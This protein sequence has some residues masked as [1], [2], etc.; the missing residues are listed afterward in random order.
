MKKSLNVFLSGTVKD[1]AP[2]REIATR[3][4]ES[5]KLEAVRMETFGASSQTPLESCRQMVQDSDVFIGIY[6]GRYG[7]V[8]PNQSQSASEI[9][10]QEAQRLGKDIMI[11]IKESDEIQ[12]EQLRF[13]QRVDDFE[14]GYFRRPKFRTLSE[15]EEWIKEDLIA[16]LSSRFVTTNVP[17]AG[18]LTD[19]YRTY[20]SN[21]YGKV[22]FA[23]LAQT[24]SGLL[25]PLQDIYIA[26][27]LREV[28][29]SK[30]TE[31][32][33]FNLGEALPTRAVI[34]GPPGS[35]KTM[36]LKHLACAAAEQ[37]APQ[38]LDRLPLLVPLISLA[39]ENSS[40][41]FFD[42]LGRFVASRTEGRF[43]SVIRDALAS[44]KT[45][46]LLDGLDEIAEPDDVDRVLFDLLTFCEQYP[47]TPVLLTT[48]PSGWR[49]IRGFLNCEIQ[50]FTDEQIFRFVRQWSAALG[51]DL[52]VS[53]KSDELLHTLVQHRYLLE[54]AR[55]PLFLTLLAFVH[56]Q[57]YRLPTRR[58]E[59]YDAYTRTMIDSWD[60][61]RSL[62]HTLARQFRQAEVED[63]LSQ[64]AFTMTTRG[65]RTIEA[66]EILSLVPD[67]ASNAEPFRAPEML[68]ALSA[69]TG[70]LDEI[71]QGR[72]SFNHI[73]F[74][75]FFAAKAIASRKFF[76]RSRFQVGY[77][78]GR[79]KST[80]VITP[81]ARAG[82]WVVDNSG[83][84]R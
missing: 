33:V 56:R 41:N 6:G 2:E 67:Y 39:E 53:A 57:G 50:P 12:N 30:E 14:G 69:R 71:A 21:L 82:P 63:F 46:L 9:E 26:P 76:E 4:I 5:L 74:Q 32:R 45:I 60:R 15:L 10:F 81:V 25:V 55:N 37:S 29:T 70:L 47:Q 27:N 7:Y 68:E 61:A 66:A 34:L 44:S 79:G 77:P 28:D 52:Q 83:A 16:L 73:A 31:A 24:P 80:S 54:L 13:L 48:R 78:E 75:E 84:I 20:V 1:L 62:S 11:Y 42:R 72:Y 17:K 40:G 38:D 58:V 22:T 3:A 8:S 23:G 49:Q 35:G 51:E 59:L 65:Q 36:L 43:D 64:V 19:Q 18:N